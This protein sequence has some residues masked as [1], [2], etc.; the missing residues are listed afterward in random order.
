MVI[1]ASN[2]ENATE[3]AFQMLVFNRVSKVTD[4]FAANAVK[5]QVADGVVRDSSK[6]ELGS[7]FVVP[8]QIHL[9]HPV[10]VLIS[11][12]C[13]QQWSNEAVARGTFTELVANLKYSTAPSSVRH[14][15]LLDEKTDA[16]EYLS[17]CPPGHVEVN[18]VFLLDK[19]PKYAEVNRM[20]LF[21]A[22]HLSRRTIIIGEPKLEMLMLDPEPDVFYSDEALP[23]KECVKK[24]E[25][26]YQYKLY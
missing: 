17:T 19:D 10:D 14:V 4:S 25:R 11:E 8:G 2:F 5:L 24:C 7:M 18:H 15:M 12:L 26:Y 16:I 1:S 3:F 20:L 13:H 9:G 22:M 6:M 23:G 21:T